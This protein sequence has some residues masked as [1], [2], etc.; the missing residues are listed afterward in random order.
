M[1]FSGRA[2]S[3]TDGRASILRNPVRS[4]LLLLITDWLVRPKL[5]SNR[6]GREGE[7]SL[8]ATWKSNA[9]TSIPHVIG[10]H[11]AV[12]GIGTQVTTTLL[13]RLR[14]PTDMNLAGDVRESSGQRLLPDFYH[15][16]QN[17]MQNAAK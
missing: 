11:D 1:Q 7:A 6:C 14:C 4:V 16:S 2:L 3:Q 13:P 9:M 12:L 17:A 15:S 5:V 8:A 10:D